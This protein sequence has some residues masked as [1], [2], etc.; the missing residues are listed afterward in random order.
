MVKPLSELDFYEILDLRVD[1]DRGEIERAYLRAVS[2]YHQD[3]L[4]SYGVLSPEA[5]ESILKKI[6][7]AFKTLSDP[8]K[9]KSYDALILP[10]RPEGRQRA[11][12]RAS[13][14]KMEIEDAADR[15]TFWRRIMVALRPLVF[16]HRRTGPTNGRERVT[17][18]NELPYSGEEL[19]I[20]RLTKGLTLEEAARSLSV[21]SSLL[22]TL[23]EGRESCLPEKKRFRLLREYARFL[24]LDAAENRK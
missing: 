12:F 4:A 20:L 24:G 11:Y 13:T 19:R 1:A 10:R 14:V 6:E 15:K 8:E 7:E 18:G 16:G 21:K 2:T 9:R 5:R 22:R 23:E 17:F 3:S